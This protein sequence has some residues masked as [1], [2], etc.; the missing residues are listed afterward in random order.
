MSAIII[1]PRQVGAAKFLWAYEE[2]RLAAGVVRRRPLVGGAV[3]GSPLGGPLDV[4][5]VEK[6]IN[7]KQG[8]EI[9]LPLLS[10]VWIRAGHLSF[11]AWLDDIFVKLKP[12]IGRDGPAWGD[13]LLLD[14][15]DHTYQIGRHHPG[16]GPDA[17][18][19]HFYDPSL[20]RAHFS[21]KINSKTATVLVADLNSHHGTAV[22]WRGME[23]NSEAGWEAVE[24]IAGTLF[25]S[26][27]AGSP[28]WRGK[29]G[30]SHKYLEPDFTLRMFINAEG[31]LFSTQEELALFPVEF[32]GLNGRIISFRICRQG[33]AGNVALLAAAIERHNSNIK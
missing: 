11:M 9:E 21:L 22:F 1:K 28:V 16:E 3:G 13:E 29:R 25:A 30:F 33:Y 4:S 5:F 32:T 23:V 18:R 12:F 15:L 7:L 10:P 8:E 26:I 2:N 31:D 14:K 17:D 19:I 24:R 27:E 20:S 6:G